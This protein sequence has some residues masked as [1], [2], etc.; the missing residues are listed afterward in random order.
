MGHVSATCD[1][2]CSTA[3]RFGFPFMFLLPLTVDFGATPPLKRQ[4]KLLQDLNW[5]VLV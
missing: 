1:R 5:P 2:L 4:L 3:G